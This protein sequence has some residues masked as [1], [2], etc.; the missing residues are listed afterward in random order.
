MQ[1]QLQITWPNNH[2]ILTESLNE[3][4]FR[5][6]W[7]IQVLSMREVGK[8][9]KIEFI[10]NELRDWP[11][12]FNNWNVEYI[13]NS[14]YRTIWF[15]KPQTIDFQP[16]LFEFVH[17][18][19]SNTEK[20]ENTHIYF[21]GLQIFDLKFTR[22]SESKFCICSHESNLMYAFYL[23]KYRNER[24]I[25]TLQILRYAIIST[26]AFILFQHISYFHF[27][28]IKEI[29]PIH[30]ELKKYIRFFGAFN[31]YSFINM[32]ACWN[33]FLLQSCSYGHFH[34][35]VCI[36]YKW[37]QIDDISICIQFKVCSTHTVCGTSFHI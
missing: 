33:F 35:I 10:D 19:P 34:F 23:H 26:Y 32:L 20:A 21:F 6:Q 14:E 24:Y 9:W 37:M 28:Q 25:S 13:L 12:L 8:Y 11:T 29:Q 2:F 1:Y 7:S 31:L 27:L 36:I 16:G 15:T 17:I 18:L 3:L 30:Y 5:I 22:N 4:T